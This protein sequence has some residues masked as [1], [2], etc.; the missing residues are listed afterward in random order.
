MTCFRVTHALLWSEKLFLFQ[1]KKL[2]SMAKMAIDL[3]D[4]RSLEKMNS[5]LENPTAQSK[6]HRCKIEGLL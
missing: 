6:T 1:T 5:I 3:T 4:P 2:R